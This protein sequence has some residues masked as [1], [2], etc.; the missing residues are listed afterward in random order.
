VPDPTRAAV[1]AIIVGSGPNGLSAAITLARAGL[2]VRLLEG[3][4]TPGGGCRT[5]EL[6]LPGFRHDICSAVH[7]LAASS[8]FFRSIDLAARGVTLCTPKVAFA[9]PL[10]GGRAAAVAGSVAETAGGLGRD[11]A[12]YR[13]LLGPLV[14]DVELT[15]PEILAPLRSVPRHPLAMARFGLDGLPPVTVL[16]RRLHTEE[17]RAL[18]AGVA[19]HSMLPLS[20]PV[21]SAFGLLLTMTAH[22]V[23]WPVVEGGSARLVDALLAELAALGGEVETGRWVNSLDELPPARAVLLDLTPRQLIALAGDRL[24]G[25][26]RAA[27]RRFRY[28]PGVCKVDWALSGPVPWQAAACQEA[29]TVHLG[30]TLAEVAHSEAEVTAGRLPDRPYC[31]VAQPGVT[32]PTRAPAGKQTLWAYCHV[33]SGCPMDASGLIEAQIERFAPGFRDLILARSVRT[34]VDLEQYNPNYVGGDINA[35]AGTLLQTVLRPTPR[36]NPY[37][38]ALPRVYLCSSST[39]PGGGVHGMCGVGAAR[40]AL[41]DL[42]ISPPG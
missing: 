23:G 22:A 2:Q 25:R 16:A 21:T 11:A 20:A 6:T 24:T 7:P 28:G 17:G 14:R 26:H 3:A 19:A 38:T 30:G 33:P 18:L 41:A 15:L 13:R 39:P 32:D 4:E 40:A 42:H 31:I 9:H 34:A 5:G 27:L 12:A 35:G 29:G 8:P 1:D 36:W 10:D 37:R